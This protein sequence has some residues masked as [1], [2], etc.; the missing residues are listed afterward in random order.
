MDIDGQIH[1]ITKG[2]KQPLPHPDR[3]SVSSSF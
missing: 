1:L 2:N 3:T